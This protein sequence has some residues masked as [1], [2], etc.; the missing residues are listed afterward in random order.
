MKLKIC[1]RYLLIILVALLFA[2]LIGPI[3]AFLSGVI[4]FGMGI[5]IGCFILCI[6]EEKWKWI[7]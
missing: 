3:I 7:R 5:C 6:I 1:V 4:G 2:Y